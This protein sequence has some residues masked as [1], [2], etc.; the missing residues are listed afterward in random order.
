MLINECYNCKLKPYWDNKILSLQLDHIN[1]IRTDNTL[2]NLRILCSNWHSQTS[3]YAGKKH[4]KY[5]F[6]IK[7][8]L[9]CCR[10]AKICKECNKKENLTRLKNFPHF[11]LINW[12]EKSAL[13]LLIWTKP[14]CDLS[15]DLDCSSNGLKKHCLKLGLKLPPKGYWIR[16]LKGY[17]HEESLTSRKVIRKPLD[18]L[19]SETVAKIKEFHQSGLGC[20]KI[21][22]ILNLHHTRISRITRGISY[23]KL[24]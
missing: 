5:H 12:P 15:K 20:R 14:A 22:R 8:S 3:N 13:E 9:P 2:E 16:R 1:G 19:N 6:C 4:K 10:S 7:C 24:S 21:G 23:R 17:S 18:L 11:K